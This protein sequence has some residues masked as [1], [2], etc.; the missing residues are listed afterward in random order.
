MTVLKEAEFSFQLAHLQAL[1]RAGEMLPLLVKRNDNLQVAVAKEEWQVGDEIHYLFHDPRPKLLKRL[2]GG[3][4]SSR[5][6]LEKLPEVEEIPL[7]A[8]VKESSS[9]IVEETI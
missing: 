6:L 1:I 4:Q 9:E 2:S 3:N 8:P 7:A 5:L